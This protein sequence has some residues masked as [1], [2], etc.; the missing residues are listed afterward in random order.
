MGQNCTFRQCSLPH[1]LISW[2][3]YSKICWGEKMNFDFNI[4]K[5]HRVIMVGKEEYPEKII[6][7]K[8]K[9][10]QHNEMIYHISGVSKVFF[11]G[12]ELMTKPGTVRFLPAGDLYEYRVEQIEPGDCIDVFFDTDIP[13]SNE[14]FVIDMSKREG[15]E[16]FFKKIFCAFVAKEEGYMLECKS[17]LYRIFFELQKSIYIPERKFRL[18]KPALEVIRSDFLAR[19]IPIHELAAASGISETYLKLLFRERF[20]LPPKKY[21]IQL[22]INYACELLRLERYTVTQIAELC[23]FSDVHY[24]S[25]QFKEYMGITPMQYSQKY[26]SSK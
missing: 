7:F 4:T 23:N 14:A 9:K 3:T 20:G 16:Q 18:I 25:R 12:K 10:V 13:F 6:E 2:K 1:I 15:L 26:K 8:S 21:I 24:F 17:Q 19:D 22:K 5:I 11:N